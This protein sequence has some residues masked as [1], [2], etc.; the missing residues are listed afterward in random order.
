MFAI[1]WSF[2]DPSQSISVHTHGQL[3]FIKK[4]SIGKNIGELHVSRFSSHCARQIPPCVTRC[5]KWLLFWILPKLDSVE[6]KEE[7]STLEK[8][9]LNKLSMSI[10][11]LLKGDFAFFI[12]EIR[13]VRYSCFTAKTPSLMYSLWHIYLNNQYSKTYQLY[14]FA[15][16]M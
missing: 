6:K 9:N 2:S 10:W 5:N 13:H 1:M 16:I 12:F 15:R 3:Q 14:Q 11:H 8:S 4:Q 7:M